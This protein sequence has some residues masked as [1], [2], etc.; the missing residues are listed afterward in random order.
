MDS[1]IQLR[2]LRKQE[3]QTQRFVS[4]TQRAFDRSQQVYGLAPEN[5]KEA[6][7]DGKSALRQ[8]RADIRDVRAKVKKDESNDDFTAARKAKAETAFDWTD[9]AE[10]E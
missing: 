4:D 1:R 7:S 8:I 6:L 3:K 2:L 10:E 5:L 9:K